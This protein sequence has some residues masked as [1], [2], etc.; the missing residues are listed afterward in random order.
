MQ[1]EAVGGIRLADEMVLADGDPTGATIAARNQ[2]LEIAAMTLGQKIPVAVSDPHQIHMDVLKPKLEEAIKAG[3][4][5]QATNGLAHYTAHWSAGVAT[6]TLDKDQINDQKQFI[7]QMQK[8]LEALAQEK[9]AAA[10]AQL[11]QPGAP[12]PF[13]PQAGPALAAQ[14]T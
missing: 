11:Q 1:A 7:A 9:A 3:M 2:E 13:P 5:E 12:V 8:A 6:K 10:Q 14:G 4:L